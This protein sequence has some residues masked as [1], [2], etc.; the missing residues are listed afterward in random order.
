M[1]DDSA[2]GLRLFKA[3][4]SACFP[5]GNGDGDNGVYIWESHATETIVSAMLLEMI[6]REGARR[7]IIHSGKKDGL[8]VWVFNPDLRYSSS[9]ADYSVSGQHAMKVFFQDV[10]D[11]ESLLQPETGKA[12]SFS[13]EE[14]HLSTSIFE[15]VVGS[16]RLSHKTLPSSARN[17]REWNVGFLKRYEK[18][19]AR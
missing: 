7:F 19:V 1:Q 18:V 2:G 17:F 3:N 12:A 4:L 6:E 14:L 16:L 8:L 9:S 5:T 13:L 10:S 11:V 15:G